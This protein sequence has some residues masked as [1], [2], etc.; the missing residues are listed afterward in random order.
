MYS[1][2]ITEDRPA[3]KRGERDGFSDTVYRL[4]DNAVMLGI[5]FTDI[6]DAV[7]HKNTGFS[8]IGNPVLGNQ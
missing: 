2:H 1:G 7:M 5:I 6:E 3:G 4:Q 8:V